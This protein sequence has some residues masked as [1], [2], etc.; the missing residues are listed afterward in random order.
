MHY[1]AKHSLHG[2][3]DKGGT[4]WLVAEDRLLKLPPGAEHFSDPGVPAQLSNPR[5]HVLAQSP[6]GAVWFAD[7]ASAR[8][9]SPGALQTKVKAI[10]NA[11]M[12]DRQGSL[13]LAT[14]D[15]D[16]LRVSAPPSIA[17]KSAAALPAGTETFT[18]SDGLRIRD[19]GIGIDL[20]V[21]SEGAGPG[22]RGLSGVRERA[23]VVGAK[24]DFWSEAGA[25]T[26]V[27]VAVPAAIAYS[28]T[29]EVRAFKWFRKTA[30]SHG[31]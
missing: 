13:W 9:V 22:H 16:I 12:I 14:D 28:K 5:E 24:L 2:W 29:G 6:G 26:E 11:V 15:N 8:P 18:K 17:G 7:R 1:S 27:Q 31:D 25:G 21:L 23:K 3:F 19:D 20:K 30:R 10:S 4:L